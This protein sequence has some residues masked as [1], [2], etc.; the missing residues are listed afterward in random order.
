MIKFLNLLRKILYKIESVN[1][2]EMNG[3]IIAVRDY[4]WALGARH[5]YIMEKL[6]V[7][8]KKIDY[9]LARC[10]VYIN[11]KLIDRIECKYEK[12]T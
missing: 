2:K 12:K 6:I 5:I 9:F 7:I 8:M 1:K 10:S 3:L 4:H 11:Q